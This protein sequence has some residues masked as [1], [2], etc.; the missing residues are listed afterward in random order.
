M[1]DIVPSN[2]TI[3]DCRRLLHHCVVKKCTILQIDTLLNDTVSANDN[4]ILQHCLVR[5]GG[6]L[7]LQTLR[8]DKNYIQ[9]WDDHFL[10]SISQVDSPCNKRGSYPHQSS[11]RWV[12]QCPSRIRPASGNTTG[13][14]KPSEGKFLSQ[15]R[16]DE[17]EFA[18][19]WRDSGCRGR[20]WCSCRRRF[21]ASPR[22]ARCSQ[23]SR[24]EQHRIWMAPP[25]ESPWWF[26]PCHEPCGSC[27]ASRGGRSRSH[28]CWRQRKAYRHQGTSWREQW[29]RQCPWARPRRR[30]W[31]PRR[32]LPWSQGQPAPIVLPNNWRQ[33]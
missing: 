21:A 10:Q 15:W 20:R 29:V 33:E 27:K 19:R 31:C 30:W 11:N 4:V 2:N 7:I 3:G 23:W 5:D 8:M 9:W 32:T 1:N 24:Q 17:L 22:T 12:F 18:S 26:P 25:Q 6:G 14:Q 13:A 16:W 28:H